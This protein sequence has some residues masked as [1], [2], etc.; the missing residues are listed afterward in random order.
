MNEIEAKIELNNITNIGSNIE[1]IDLNKLSKTKLLEK[2]QELKIKQ[3]KSTKYKN[4]EELINL[5]KNKMEKK[6][7]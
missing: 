6:K 5:L 3:M 4:K 7:G 2:C 1:E